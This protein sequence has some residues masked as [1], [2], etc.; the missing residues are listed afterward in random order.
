MTAVGGSAP[1]ASDPAFVAPPI[2]PPA[3]GAPLRGEQLRLVRMLADQP[4]AVLD[5][6]AERCE[7]VHLAAG[8]VLNRPGDPAEWMFLMLA[9][10]LRTRRDALG[11]AAPIFVTRAGDTSGVLP[12]SRMTT[13]PGTTRATS[14]SVV[15]RFPRAAFA[16]LLHVA[17][18]LEPRFVSLL[19]DRVRDVTARDQ[20]FEKL[21]ALGRLA[22]GLAHE[23]NNPAAAAQR[24]ARESRAQL[25][26]ALA[27]TAALLDAG[28]DGAALRA[29]ATRLDLDA[30]RDG[31]Y[32]RRPSDP[33]ERADREDA[34]RALLDRAGL[35]EGWR[36]APA[37]VD[38]GL[39]ADQLAD[40]L[41]DVPA[42]A[43]APVLA[44]LADMLGAAASL[45]VVEH[46]VQRMS[47]LVRDVRTYTNLDHPVA[48]EL[49]DVRE[50][51]RSALAMAQPRLR[52]RRV[53]L[54]CEIAEQGEHG[55]PFPPVRGVPVALNEVWS[56]LLQN[57]IDAAPAER[58]TVAVRVRVDGGA[59]VVEVA[60]D[61][62]GVP[63]AIR[64]QVWEPFFTTKDVGAGT[65]LGLA[66]ARRVVSEHGGEIAL[67]S[68]PGD[69]RARVTLPAVPHLA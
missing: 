63:P 37:L 25:G 33:L 46:A 64:D 4:D 27:G 32:A 69:T 5:W 6:I 29:L 58:G 53:R 51:V 68:V 34:V 62:P 65:G 61:G 35:R 45:D 10:E 11:A 9:G 2:A 31:G 24:G 8:E 52:D 67:D 22:A 60:D 47:A 16:E 15:A 14:D 17:P 3:P 42:A 57:A 54:T 18:A 55:E 59:V 41:A 28:L 38:A 13:W 49:M 26:D 23:L 56:A 12:F 36:A 44:W 30:G 39:R 1:L 40:A 21:N 19:T 66:I 20:Q 50:G 48:I 43:H 7:V